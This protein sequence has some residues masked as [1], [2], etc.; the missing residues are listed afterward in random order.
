M[1]II[2]FVIAI[3]AAHTV[4]AQDTL[5]PKKLFQKVSGGAIFAESASTS[6]SK[7][8]KPFTIGQ[9]LLANV[10]VITPK[11]FHNFFYSFGGNNIATLNGY[12]L[13]RGWDTYVIYAKSLD[14]D[15]NYLGL[16]IEKMVKV[17]EGVNIFLFTEVGT[18]FAGKMSVTFGLLLSAQC[19]IWARK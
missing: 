5:N 10:L 13:P 6:F 3:L 17:H 18:G 16:G 9:N 2:M 12:F 19:K 15:G 11:T 7:E 4:V 8:Q 14:S 1:K